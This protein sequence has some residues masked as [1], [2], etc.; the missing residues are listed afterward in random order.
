MSTHQALA[1]RWRP[2]SF[3]HFVGQPHAVKALQQSLE[4]KHIHHAHLFTGT[5]GVGKTTLAR[6]FAK[7]L[8]CTQGITSNPCGVCAHCTAITQGNFID[9]IEIDA[10]SRTKVEDTKELLSQVNYPPVQGRFKIYLIDEVHSLSANSFN[11]LLKT[12]EEP[13]EHV[14]FILATTDPQK[15][16][17]TI[18]SRCLQLHLQHHKLDDIAGHLRHVAENIGKPFEDEAIAQIAEAASGSL[19]D[20]LSLFEQAVA[21]AED[22]ITNQTVS[23]MFGRAEEKDV[24]QL[25]CAI[26]Q[27]DYSIIMPILDKLGHTATSYASILDQC[28]RALYQII[29]IQLLSSNQEAAAVKRIETYEH[30]AKIISSE[31]LQ[32][33]VDMIV[34]TKNDLDLYPSQEMGFNMLVMRM[35][36]FKLEH[37]NLS[38]LIMQASSVSDSVDLSA[39]TNHAA[40]AANLTTTQSHAQDILKNKQPKAAEQPRPS[41]PIRDHNQPTSSPISSIRPP[42]ASTIRQSGNSEWEA[43][44]SH[45]L[46]TGMMR[47]IFQQSQCRVDQ[48]HPD[49]W[50]IM[51]DPSLG[52][53]ITP[54]FKDRAS[55]LCHSV[56]SKTVHL[57]FTISEKKTSSEATTQDKIKQPPQPQPKQTTSNS[58]VLK[59]NQQLNQ[60]AAELDATTIDS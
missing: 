34:R 7:G 1:R 59:S 19:R 17:I 56:L 6:V 57:N 3:D 22:S 23:A 32:L 8:S 27:R 30:A 16:P 37:S 14:K 58:D 12:L 13:P 50:E 33:Y 48:Q 5:R 21:A 18:L 41:A 31:Q 52:K 47:Q 44:L 60:F 51:V 53:L 9:L 2:Q 36:A 24:I 43:V 28:L 55:Q 20:A 40:Q 39:V 25:L 49:Q 26:S 4:R 42:V 29:Q 11:A 35:S 46:C 45:Q 38:N 10:A 54:A 15:L